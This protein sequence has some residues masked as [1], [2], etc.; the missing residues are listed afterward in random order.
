MSENIP[1]DPFDKVS[2]P[3]L[4]F[5][6]VPMKTVVQFHVAKYPEM[7]QGRDFDSGE[8]KWWPANA[9][10]TRNPVMC[11]VI[12]GTVNGE[13]RAI[14]ARKPSSMF[15]AIMKAQKDSG[16]R[17][18]PGSLLSLVQTGEE[19]NK[20]RKKAAQKIYAAKHEPNAV[21]VASQS[22][23]FAQP[24][25]SATTAETNPW[26]ADDAAPAAKKDDDP[27]PF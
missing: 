18:A 9:D 22:D 7:V 5:K 13:E 27:P 3:S 21:P 14:W 1:D 24:A 8:A 11:A 19:P 4:S 6:D 2:I 20:D 17:I 26:A 10:G 25:A 12:T 16:Q 23:P 15:S